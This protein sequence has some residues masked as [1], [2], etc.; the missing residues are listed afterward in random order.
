MHTN[1]DIEHVIR[2]FIYKL[3]NALKRST[4]VQGIK[5]TVSKTLKEDNVIKLPNKH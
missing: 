4:K 2:T 5:N 1:E 3:N